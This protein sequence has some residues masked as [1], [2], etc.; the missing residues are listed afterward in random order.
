MVR[1]FM[2]PLLYILLDYSD[3]K[4]EGSPNKH[5]PALFSS[6]DFAYSSKIDSKKS[7]EFS[8]NRK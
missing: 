5:T 8:V 4:I 7:L 1:F 3:L 6:I 2:R